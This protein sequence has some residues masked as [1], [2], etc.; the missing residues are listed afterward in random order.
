MR[1]S[2]KIKDAWKLYS[3]SAAVEL[4]MFEASE[5]MVHTLLW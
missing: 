5:Q 3:C 1:K 4:Q 2:L